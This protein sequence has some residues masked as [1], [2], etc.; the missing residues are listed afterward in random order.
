VNISKLIHLKH[1][2]NKKMQLKLSEGYALKRNETGGSLCE[3]YK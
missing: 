2:S 3:P 1:E